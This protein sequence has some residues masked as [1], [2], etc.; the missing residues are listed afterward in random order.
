MTLSERQD[1]E[2]KALI[3]EILE[4]SQKKNIGNWLKTERLEKALKQVT[5]DPENYFKEIDKEENE[6]N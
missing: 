4:A 6:S 2:R 5:K 1:K 3:S